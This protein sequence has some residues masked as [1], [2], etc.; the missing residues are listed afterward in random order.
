MLPR[1]SVHEYFSPFSQALLLEQKAFQVKAGGPILTHTIFRPKKPSLF[2]AAPGESGR[3]TGR[4]HKVTQ[5]Q[6]QTKGAH[7]PQN[8]PGQR[9]RDTERWAEVK[10]SRP[11]ESGHCIQ[12]QGSVLSC[13]WSSRPSSLPPLSL[14]PGWDP[15]SQASA[16][17]REE[18]FSPEKKSPEHRHY[19]L[20]GT[21]SA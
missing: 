9:R 20:F 17:Q 11:Q 16:F 18:T 14:Q 21:S 6:T 3:A 10:A 13:T 12:R 8:L 15:S 7:S 5:Q 19:L 2:Q 4:G 1:G